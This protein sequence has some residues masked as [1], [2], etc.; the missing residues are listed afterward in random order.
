MNKK[1]NGILGLGLAAALVLSPIGASMALAVDETPTEQPSTSAN[2]D[3]VVD[4][5]NDSNDA[6]EA[7]DTP[8]SSA[9]PSAAPSPSTSPSPSA[10]PSDDSVDED[11]GDD[12]DSDDENSDGE[13]ANGVTSVT[14]YGYRNP[15]L[16]VT[17]NIVTT[18][19]DDNSDIAIDGWAVIVVRAAPS[20][21]AA[22]D[23]E[24]DDDS[25]DSSEESPFVGAAFF[26]RSATS[27]VVRGGGSAEV[28][29]GIDPDAGQALPIS[30]APLANDAEYTVIVTP[31]YHGRVVPVGL[32]YGTGTTLDATPPAP[33]EPTAAST[34]GVTATIKDGVVTASLNG[35]AAGT[36]VYG[37][38]F[39][40]PTALGW[41][42]VS[43]TGTASFSLATA[44]LA[45][46]IH[47]LAVLDG[48]G[49]V[50]GTAAFTVGAT[51]PTAVRALAATGSD[52]A[53]P[54]GAA[55]ALLL[56]G[57]TLLVV[58]RARAARAQ[59]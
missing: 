31:A 40:T 41:A 44:G 17:W 46:G 27:G 39:S 5:T 20:V 11:A 8:G 22:A 1:T 2:P 9:S 47:H 59:G 48:D 35:V 32:A 14:G 3:L 6:N 51:S 7:V 37:Y 36:E 38:A 25:D 45:D 53:L 33:V 10:E 49:N 19:F 15:G 4:E 52:A 26:P 54:L 55:G 16:R 13:D 42:T 30:Q 50:I 56:A 57:L 43:P 24:G 18:P 29:T 12:E 28:L 58:R 21:D 23:D 34:N